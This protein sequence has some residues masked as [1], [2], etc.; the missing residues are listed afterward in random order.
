MP[1]SLIPYHSLTSSFHTSSLPSSSPSLPSSSLQLPYQK[2]LDTLQAPGRPH[3]AVNHPRRQRKTDSFPR[4][5]RKSSRQDKSRKL[6][7]PVDT[8]PYFFIPSNRRSGGLESHSEGGNRGLVERL[9]SY[10][11]LS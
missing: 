6:L 8:R 10:W 1:L 5:D 4:S 9:A 11:G 7:L 2:E 3:T